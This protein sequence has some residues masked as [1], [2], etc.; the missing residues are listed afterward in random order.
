MKFILILLYVGIVTAAYSQSYNERDRETGVAMGLS[1]GYSSKQCMIGT[2]S[3]GAML[4]AYNHLSVNMVVLSALKNADIPSI[5]EARIAHVFATFELY[6]GA[7]YH[8]AGADNKIASNPNTGIRAAY[9][10]IKHF[11][12]SPWTVSAGMSG[13]IFSLQIGLFGVR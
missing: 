2:L 3:V 1:G 11:Y 10:I 5:F 6:G 12:N 13:N 8:I 7:G 9:G 4:P